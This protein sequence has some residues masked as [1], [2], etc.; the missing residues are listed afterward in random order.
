MPASS[1]RPHQSSKGVHKR[2]KRPKHRASSTTAPRRSLPIAAIARYHQHYLPPD[3]GPYEY[4]TI[5]KEASEIRLMTILPGVFGSEVRITIQN[6]AFTKSRIPMYEAL[7]YAWGSN[8]RSAKIRIETIDGDRTLAVTSNLAEALQHLRFETRPRVLWIDAICVDQQ[9]VPER[10]HQVSRMVDI[11]RSASPVLIWLGP[12][13]ASSDVAMRELSTL[14]STMRVDWGSKE[15]IPL[16]G[17]SYPVW[18]ATPY[19]F[20]GHGSVSRSIEA[21]L[22]RL[23]FK[24]LWIWQEVRL[25]KIGTKI[26]C[27]DKIMLWETFRNAMWDFRL[28]GGNWGYKFVSLINHISDFCNYRRPQ[29]LILDILEVTKNCTYSDPRDRI[30]AI[31]NLAYPDEIR[32]FEP[33]YSKSTEEV[34]RNF[35]MSYTSTHGTLKLLSHCEMRELKAVDLP[36]WV[37]DWT[38]PKECEDLRLSTACWA[39]KGEAKFDDLRTLRVTARCVGIVDS[40]H[41]ARQDLRTTT[42]LVV[43]TKDVPFFIQRF[44]SALRKEKHTD[45]TD[46]SIIDAFCRT[47]CGNAFSESYLPPFRSSPR[48]QESQA[49]MLNLLN[50]NV[51]PI[52]EDY[53]TSISHEIKNRA[54]FTTKEGKIGL[55]PRRTETEDRLCIVLGCQSPLVLRANKNGNHTVVGDCYLDGVMDGAGLLGQLPRKWQRVSRYDPD[56]NNSHDAF[57]NRDTGI[58]QLEDPRLGP[59][60]PGWRI[61]DHEYKQ[62]LTR[63]TN[64]AAGICCSEFDPRMSAEALKARGIDLQEYRLV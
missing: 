33:D 4:T 17:D 42:S 51:G 36:S 43:P 60:P 14:G 50:G 41:H 3:L 27:G 40:I 21:L 52:C 59:L 44:W 28:K 8:Q 48:W 30:H 63:Y 37:P 9:N 57:I 58:V 34:F 5:D 62:I 22:D 2:R 10:S 23:W 24:R 45:V 15:I 32:G 11:Y 31:L 46:K 12:E 47:L 6:H 7:S 18:Q 49:Y 56:F 13:F 61:A 53:I 26:L 55:A 19:P 16:S 64:D 29:S 35:V 39:S 1:K 20:S 38:I 54:L 25:A